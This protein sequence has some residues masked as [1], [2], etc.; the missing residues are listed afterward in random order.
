MIREHH[1]ASSMEGGDGCG[2]INGQKRITTH[3]KASRAASKKGF[4]FGRDAVQCSR[5]IGVIRAMPDDVVALGV[6]GG[7]GRVRAARRAVRST[8]RGAARP[9]RA[10]FG[11]R[12]GREGR[13]GARGLRSTEGRTR[14]WVSTAVSA[15][16]EGPIRVRRRVASTPK[17]AWDPAA[18]GSQTCAS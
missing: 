1:A 17:A 13:T 8:P 15:W 9:V 7:S 10:A 16:A 5:N 2:I 6:D 14:G 4:R 12:S 11:P 18:W 3:R